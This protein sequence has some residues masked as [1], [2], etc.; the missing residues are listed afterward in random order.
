[1]AIHFY[2]DT[3]PFCCNDSSYMRFRH[4]V[5]LLLP[6]DNWPSYHAKGNVKH[7]MHPSPSSDSIHI[8][9][10]WTSMIRLTMLRPAPVPSLFLRLL[11][12]HPYPE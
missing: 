12:I 7:T 8:R 3:P 9:P 5:T 11:Q 1:M 4:T 2:R 6:I 10:P